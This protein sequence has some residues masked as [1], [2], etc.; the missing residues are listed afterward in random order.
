MADEP[1]GPLDILKG[2][3]LILGHTVLEDDTGD[4]EGVEP[5][6][7]FGAFLIVGEDAVAATRADDDRGG[8]F[9]GGDFIDRERRLGDVS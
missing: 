5:S 1:H 8:G 4:T 2:A 6:G 9:V 7:D 3:V